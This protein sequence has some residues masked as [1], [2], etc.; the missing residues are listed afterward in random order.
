MTKMLTLGSII[1]MNGGLIQTGPF[2][3]QLHQSDYS[4]EGIPVVMPK[5]I[6]DGRI[7][8]SSIA[9][10]PEEKASQLSRHKLKQGSIV[11]PR[12]GDISKCAYIT[13]SQEGYLCGT[14]CIKIEV[15]EEVI[16]P[17]FL[18]YYLGLRQV[19]EWLERNAV[20]TTMLNLNTSIIAG[21]Q[22]PSL[23]L[24]QQKKI[25]SI[26]ET[27]D[28]LIGNNLRRIE[29]L[30]Q[31]VRLLYKE[32]FLKFQFPGYKKTNFVDGIPENWN[33]VRIG[34]FVEFLGGFP[35]ESKSY[36]DSGK[37]GIVTIKNVHD[38]KFITECSAY[39]DNI[40][41]GMKE[42][43]LIETGDI[44]MSL[45]GNV[46]RVCIV[47]GEQYLLNQRVAKLKPLKETPKSFVY[48]TFNNV[49][50][51]K[52]IENLSSGSAQQN[53]SP[54]K[55]RKKEFIFPPNE[56]LKTFDQYAGGIFNLICNLN[57]ANQRLRKARDL[58]IPRLMKGEITE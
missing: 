5:D 54:V 24:E 40:P 57:H 16:Y 11:F 48:W 26:L 25:A 4:D 56:L 2:G 23:S 22:I 15:P 21:I 3:S 49:V 7:D 6:K 39:I 27:Y 51:Q 30:E 35:F 29:L 1:E 14:G 34:D 37:Y 18:F 38:A 55:L 47:I 19:V 31:S 17:K 32:W 44:L 20:G 43:C 9:R 12:R 58:L 8:E 46:G 50:I 36:Q 33:K 52:E 28:E 10:I 13:D 42:Y 53:L 45:T 41:N